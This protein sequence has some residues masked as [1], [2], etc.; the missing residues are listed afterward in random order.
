M[1]QAAR[2]RANAEPIFR[3]VP[4]IS[5]SVDCGET[6][7]RSVDVQRRRFREDRHSGG[8]R[9]S[10]NLAEKTSRVGEAGENLLCAGL[11]RY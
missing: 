2:Y 1:C 11:Q 10:A 5:V 6:F 9:V 8:S 7:G 4:A 3:C